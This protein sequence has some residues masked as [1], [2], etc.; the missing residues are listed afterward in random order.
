MDANLWFILL[1]F[2]QVQAT[3]DVAFLNENWDKITQALIWLEYQDMNECGLLE[4]PEAG[5]WM[6]L[7]AVRYNAL[8]DN[9]LYYA[10]VLAYDLMWKRLSASTIG[11]Q[12]N[13]N[14]AQDR[15]STRLNSSHGGISR[16]PSSA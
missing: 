2:L 11:H 16:M 14:A 1:H 8:Y 3:D 6:D 10:A 4:I 5:N 7:I 12:V 15:K 9:V 13:V